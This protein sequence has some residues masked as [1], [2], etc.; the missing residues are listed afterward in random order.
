DGTLTL[1]AG[2]TTETTLEFQNGVFIPSGY[3]ASSRGHIT[4]PET[5]TCE[6]TD[7]A[8]F[9][10]DASFPNEIKINAL[11][12]LVQARPNEQIPPKPLLILAD[13]YNAQAV[14]TFINSNNGVGKLLRVCP[15]NLP[16]MTGSDRAREF[17]RDFLSDYAVLTGAS[18]MKREWGDTFE[19]NVSDE[20]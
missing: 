20:Y 19:Q 6:Y 4:N 14:M 3:D 1:L 2:N 17:R 7:C 12:K 15:V 10:Y 11:L 5:Q 13:S 8:V 9:L 18:L 16:P